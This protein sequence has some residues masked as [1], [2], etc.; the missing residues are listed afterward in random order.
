VENKKAETPVGAMVFF[1]RYDGNVFFLG[2]GTDLIPILKLGLKRHLTLKDLKRLR[3][4][5]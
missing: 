4:M 1:R 2:G 3:S 5:R